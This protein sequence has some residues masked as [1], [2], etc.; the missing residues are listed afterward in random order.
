MDD[1]P[2]TIKNEL[3]ILPS[4]ISLM[5]LAGLMVGILLVHHASL[6]S[7]G[8]VVASM[9]VALACLYAV[10]SLRPLV[11][12]CVI[13]LVAIVLG[14]GV[15]LLGSDKKIDLHPEGTI[16]ATG[17]VIMA[18]AM[19]GERQRIRFLPDESVVSGDWRLIIPKDETT[20]APGDRAQ[21]Q[22]RL[23]HPLPQLLPGGF[24]FTAHAT[25]KGYSATG[26]LQEITP[27]GRSEAGRIARLRYHIQERI[28]AAMEPNNAAIASALLVGL[29]GII[30]P[31]LREEFRGSGLAHL[32]AISGLHMALFCGS[33][34]LALRF[35]LAFFPIFSSRF[36]AMKI[37][38]LASLPFGFFYLMIAG[39]PIS[40]VRAFG[41]ICFVIL[42]LILNR[43]G[44]TL[45]HVALMAIAILVVSPSSLFDPAFQMS[46]AAVF[47]LVAGWM[48]RQNRG[49]SKPKSHDSNF[50]RI[51]QYAG[52]IMVASLLASLGSAPFVLYHFGLTT[53]WS[54]LANL[55]GMPL[56]GMFIMPMGII[57][58]L[59]IPLGLDDFSFRMMGYGLGVLIEAARFFS[60]IPLSELRVKP[61]PG[62]TIVLITLAVLLPFIVKGRLR[63]GA[64]VLLLCA[65]GLWVSSSVPV[66][67][68]ANFHGKIHAV[69]VDERG[70]AISSRRMNDFTKAVMLRVFGLGSAHYARDAE[71]KRL[72]DAV[73]CEKDACFITLKG[74][75]EAAFI[76][77]SKGIESAC[78]RAILVIAMTSI[79]EFCSATLIDRELIKQKGGV[80]ITRNRA[81][82]F[83]LRHVRD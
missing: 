12:N 74:G 2:S 20:L 21:L 9:V 48:F 41:M 40:A 4:A 26:F 16:T 50:Q 76:W 24:D 62:L 52:G 8:L 73:I 33:V 15:A 42:A 23:T 1:S 70:T 46:F 83:S 65:G 61:P 37:A 31:E 60:D 35:L 81:G 39:V 28:T 13:G 78:E 58:L 79:D 36:P 30:P 82:D 57:A 32:L 18:E 10:R 68:V 47:A 66:V 27:I 64:G 77:H 69:V 34:L 54:I 19:Y 29:R 38:A 11:I 51:F 71:R 49:S 17:T 67:A 14:S 25:S 44:M 5:V 55:I 22:A 45:H 80:L 75:G 43:R 59:T 72:S 3:H 7:G 56:M 53:A 63:Y 6:F